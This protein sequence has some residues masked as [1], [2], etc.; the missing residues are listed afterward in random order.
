MTAE[1]PVHTVSLVLK[2]IVP[3]DLNDVGAAAMHACFSGFTEP[4]DPDG[5]YARRG[6]ELAASR[7]GNL[8]VSHESDLS[9]ARRF[10]GDRSL[11]RGRYFT[12]CHDATGD[13]GG[14]LVREL[15]AYH[16]PLKSGLITVIDPTLPDQIDRV[17]EPARQLEHQ[18]LLLFPPVGDR[19]HPFAARYTDT[20]RPMYVALPMRIARH[21]ID[22]VIDLRRPD[23][24]NWFAAALSR[25]E[26]VQSHRAFPFKPPLDSFA[27]LL[28]SLLCQSIGG[29]RGPV[30]VAGLWLRR[31]GVKGLIFPSSRSDCRVDLRGGEV[32]TA[33]GFNFV[34][35]R[36]AAEPEVTAAI[37]F[38][39]GWPETVQTWRDDYAD[40]DEVVVY[41][42]VE[43]RHEPAGAWRVDGLQMRRDAP[44]QFLGAVWLMTQLFGEEDPDVRNAI[45]LIHGFLQT[46]WRPELSRDLVNALMGLAGPRAKILGFVDSPALDREP[47]VR[48]SVHKLLDRTPAARFS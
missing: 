38:S 4:I 46:M 42:T 33:T 45:G 40:D 31:L 16:N 29:G 24:A 11:G 37:D 18:L 41:D 48:A 2:Q 25:L 1:I 14:T 23:V 21:E 19:P 22:G 44:Y 6:R 9:P 7:F 10:A 35:Y 47:D 3:E 26:V 20:G 5:D 17:P 15:T 39:V 12:V 36:G 27:D 28:P 30:Q 8:G 32:V 13:D 43:I 34:D